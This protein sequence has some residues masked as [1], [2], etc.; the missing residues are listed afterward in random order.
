[1]AT[2]QRMRESFEEAMMM[3]DEGLW[4]EVVEYVK[5]VVLVLVVGL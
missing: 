4:R 5:E 1:M 3:K 2:M